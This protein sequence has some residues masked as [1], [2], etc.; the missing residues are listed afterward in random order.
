[1]D[2]LTPA[3]HDAAPANR[4]IDARVKLFWLLVVTI[5]AAQTGSKGLAVVSISVAGAALWSPIRLSVLAVRLYPL[6]MLLFAV[7]L[8]RAFSTAGEPLMAFF[9]LVLTR[10]GLREGSL[11]CWR[12]A[13]I[14]VA[15][16]VFAAATP[17][18]ELRAALFWLLRPLFG[19]RAGRVATLLALV[20]RF[21]VAIEA[22]AR[23]VSLAQKARCVDQRLNPFYRV[24]VF[25]F[26]LLVKSLISA[27]RLALAMAAR[28][29]TDEPTDPD[30]C[31]GLK[32]AGVLAMVVGI[33]LAAIAL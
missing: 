18:A 28:C 11:I 8:T 22:H 20:L 24:R 27:D 10:E 17:P 13:M 30:F 32:D 7:M 5:V 23:G 21:V 31:F 33:G 4:R 1:M 12:L 15:G 25:A 3:P 9:S 14:A 26:P 2:R 6:L 29:Y 16:V 19:V